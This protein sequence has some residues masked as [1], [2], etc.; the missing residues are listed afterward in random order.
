VLSDALTESAP[1]TGI[2]LSPAEYY[3]QYVGI[4]RW[5]GRKTI[6]VS[7]FHDSFLEDARHALSDKRVYPQGVDSLRWKLNPVAVCDGGRLFFSVE[8]DPETRSFGRV[9]FSDRAG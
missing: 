5:T 7:G 1:A 3:R 8:Y 9:V 4:W 6:Y 2:S